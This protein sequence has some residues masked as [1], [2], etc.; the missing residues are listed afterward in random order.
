[1]THVFA[2]NIPNSEQH[3]VAFVVACTVLV[4]LTK[5]TK[6]DW[7]VGCGNYF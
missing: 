6:R 1:M 2:S 3:A 4:R 5:I 7:A